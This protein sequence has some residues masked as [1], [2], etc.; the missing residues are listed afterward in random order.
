MDELIGIGELVTAAVS[1]F[2]AA[3]SLSVARRAQRDSRDLARIALRQGATEGLQSWSRACLGTI[4]EAVRTPPSDREGIAAIRA[5]LSRYVDEGRVFFPVREDRSQEG[6]PRR[7][8]LGNDLMRLVDLMEAGADHQPYAYALRH[9]WTRA[10]SAFFYGPD[11]PL[12]DDPA[13]ETLRT[14]GAY[15]PHKDWFEENYPRARISPA[16]RPVRARTLKRL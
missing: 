6:K 5:R 8:E 12:A 16:P 3:V 9:C 1:L 14:N 11:S 15:A 10:L 7:Y 13:Y 2:V 4:A